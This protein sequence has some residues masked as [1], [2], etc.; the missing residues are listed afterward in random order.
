MAYRQC[1][2]RVDVVGIVVLVAVL[3]VLPLVASNNALDACQY[4]QVISVDSTYNI[5]ACI[6]SDT[7]IQQQCDSDT[8]IQLQCNT[9]EQAW[10]VL[11]PNPQANLV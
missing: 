9:L 8:I 10:K 2:R 3:V 4:N 11:L 5:T 6:S 1:G 7:V